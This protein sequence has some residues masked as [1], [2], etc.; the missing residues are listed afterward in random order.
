MVRGNPTPAG[1]LT[2]RAAHAGHKPAGH[3]CPDVESGIRPV[4]G[5]AGARPEV[6][7]NVDFRVGPP[8]LWSTRH[9]CASRADSAGELCEGLFCNR[10]RGPPPSVAERHAEVGLSL[11][12]PVLRLTPVVGGVVVRISQ[13]ATVV[14]RPV[15]PR[16]LALGHDISEF[17]QPRLVPAR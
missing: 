10:R 5:L 1:P 17:D 16:G 4:L 6:F 3:P 8:P 15:F 13:V 2:D 12:L 9:R 7:P 11:D 14:F